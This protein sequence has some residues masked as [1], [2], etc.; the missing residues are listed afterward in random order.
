MKIIVDTREQLPLWI[1][2]SKIIKKKL[3]VG[4]YSTINL[5]HSFC[6]ER[7]SG[8]D[9]YGS[10]LQGHVRFRKELV[11]ARVNNIKLVIYVECC[12]KDFELKK[13]PGGERR[14]C[15][16]ETLIKI[17]ETISKRHNVEVVWCSNRDA[18]VKKILMRLRREEK[19]LSRTK[20]P[21]PRKLKS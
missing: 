3:L 14:K 13:F 5:E 2:G 15:P 18:L 7:K 9:L 1:V 20:V 19:L 12:K 11:R 16:G 4:D 17:I 21:S 6:V 10:I 8:Q